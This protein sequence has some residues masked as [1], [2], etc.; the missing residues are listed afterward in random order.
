MARRRR[1]FDLGKGIY[2][3]HARRGNTDG[4]RVVGPT[5]GLRQ[6]LRS[7]IAV[8]KKGP[9]LELDRWAITIHYEKENPE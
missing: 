2:W 8:G 9:V 6:T 3:I 5:K 4:G 1:G 7:E